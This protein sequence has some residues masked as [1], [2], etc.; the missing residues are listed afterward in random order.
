MSRNIMELLQALSS[1][2]DEKRQMMQAI[3]EAEKK[4]RDAGYTENDWFRLVMFRQTFDNQAGTLAYHLTIATKAGDKASATL[5]KAL[6][7]N[8]SAA[9][10]RNEEMMKRAGIDPDTFGQKR[11]LTQFRGRMA[12]C[13]AI[14]DRVL[15]GE[16]LSELD[17][18]QMTAGA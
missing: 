13:A 7:E 2:S 15:A 4:A 1:M 18:A 5:G 16:D 12:R 8:I 10:T 3:E 9:A 14:C 11:D 6:A 17:A